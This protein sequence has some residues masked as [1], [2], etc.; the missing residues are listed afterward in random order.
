LH[1]NAERFA[2]QWAQ[3]IVFSETHATEECTIFQTYFARRIIEQI[4][5]NIANAHITGS[6]ATMEAQEQ[7]TQGATWKVWC[8]CTVAV[9]LGL[10]NSMLV[11]KLLCIPPTLNR[12]KNPLHKLCQMPTCCKVSKTADI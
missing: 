11:D 10:L 12:S 7:G 1:E 5:R 3:G 6:N 4:L 2:Q 8:L 9:I